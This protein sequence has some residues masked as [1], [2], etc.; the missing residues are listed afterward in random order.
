MNRNKLVFPIFWLIGWL[1]VNE[2]GFTEVLFVYNIGANAD[3]KTLWSL[4]QPYGDITKVN[5]GWRGSDT[6]SMIMGCIENGIVLIVRALVENRRLFRLE[7]WNFPTP[8]SF[9]CRT[10]LEGVLVSKILGSAQKCYVFAKIFKKTCKN[11]I[12]HPKFGFKLQV[13]K[14]LPILNLCLKFRQNRSSRTRVISV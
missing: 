13:Q 11:A 10:I 5:R 9:T 8:Q 6:P 3:E 14:I 4:F 2:N 12:S 7:A 1:S